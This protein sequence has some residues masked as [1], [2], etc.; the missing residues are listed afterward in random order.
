MGRGSL[1]LLKIKMSLPHLTPLARWRT[2]CGR[3]RTG[4]SLKVCT[5][6]GLGALQAWG[7]G[8]L[9]LTMAPFS[10]PHM[11][12]SRSSRWPAKNSWDSWRKTQLPS[13]PV[14]SQ[15]FRIQRFWFSS[16]APSIPASASSAHRPHPDPASPRRGA[17]PASFSPQLPA[18]VGIP[19]REPSFS[20]LSSGENGL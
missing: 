10:W 8:C 18:G 14:L 19:G 15:R 16:P 3:E 12:H 5:L 17:G 9:V 4:A 20:S 2:L 7:G 6:Q 1:P 11:K 13:L